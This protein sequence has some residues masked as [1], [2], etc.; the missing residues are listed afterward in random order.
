MDDFFKKTHCDRCGKELTDGR[1]MSQFNEDCLCLECKSNE[2][3]HSDYD[4]AIIAEIKEI[5]RCNYNFKGVGFNT[6]MNK[7]PKCLSEDIEPINKCVLLPHVDEAC[8]LYKCTKCGCEFKEW[9][10]I[11][12]EF[13]EFIQK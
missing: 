8:I 1:I 11:E 9:Y 7:C 2:E 10:K 3:K 4:K 6:E 5:K 13:S 12:Y